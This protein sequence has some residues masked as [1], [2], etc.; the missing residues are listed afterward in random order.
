VTCIA[1]YAHTSTL[2]DE[3]PELRELV[4]RDGA[5]P[6]NA[7]LPANAEPAHSS[8]NNEDDEEDLESLRALVMQSA[9]MRVD[10]APAAT[11]P[12][13][14][15]STSVTE[16]VATASTG[17]SNASTVDAPAVAVAAATA[18]TTASTSAPSST[19]V[20]DAARTSTARAAAAHRAS[21]SSALSAAPSRVGVSFDVVKRAVAAAVDTRP[22]A[23]K[24]KRVD[25]ARV[26][27]PAR[28]YRAVARYVSPLIGMRAYRVCGTF[29]FGA[30]GASVA[31]STFS[32]RIDPMRA[33]CRY[34]VHGV[35]LDV[36]CAEQVRGRGLRWSCGG[37]AEPCV[38]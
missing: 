33:L 12:S 29:A 17:A 6:R 32:H 9:S 1:E 35:C 20:T 11:E 18:A 28:A 27:A 7:I 21:Q 38:M 26:D 23:R 24:R 14:T 22:V 2:L 16:Q 13:R 3:V 4:G 15:V 5:Q 36:H 10:A 25:T 30:R 34:D 37:V 19:P 31:S 8:S